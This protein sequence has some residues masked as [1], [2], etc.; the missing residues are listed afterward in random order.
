MPA[1]ESSH[2]QFPWASISGFPRITG[3]GKS[4]ES[5]LHGPMSM[6]TRGTDRRRGDGAEDKR[7]RERRRDDDAPDAGRSRVP[8]EW[9]QAWAWHG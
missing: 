3:Q 8:Q 4:G 1:P 9:F 6:D 2:L 7:E 5:E